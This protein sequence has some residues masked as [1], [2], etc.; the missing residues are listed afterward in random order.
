MRVR[1]G[2]A[3]AVAAVGL[4]IGAAAVPAAA[5]GGSDNPSTQCATTG[6]G[7]VSHGGCTSTAARFGSADLEN[8]P[9]LSTSAFVSNCK[10]LPALFLSMVPPIESGVYPVTIGLHVLATP[11]AA[12]D[13]IFHD[14]FGPNM[15][16]CV[17]ILA[18][19]HATIADPGPDGPYDVYYTGG[20]GGNTTFA[21]GV[22]PELGPFF[23]P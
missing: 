3:A 21:P 19:D 11:A 6:N 23:G 13:Y 10:G 12:A 16:T 4:A 1:L 22:P 17:A 18:A 20:N 15:S 8:L 2:V 5:A 14:I 7:D 9:Y